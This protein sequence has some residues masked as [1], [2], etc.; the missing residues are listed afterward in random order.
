MSLSDENCLTVMELYLRREAHCLHAVLQEGKHL[1]LC[2]EDVL[3]YCRFV[4]G[5]QPCLCACARLDTM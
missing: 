4:D 1:C 3:S 2:G 5:W